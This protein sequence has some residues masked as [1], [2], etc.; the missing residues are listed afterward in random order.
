LRTRQ[1]MTN[2]GGAAGA[3]QHEAG[4]GSILAFRGSDWFF[5]LNPV[6]PRWCL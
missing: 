1:G 3:S 5:R 6:L 2:C 4:Q